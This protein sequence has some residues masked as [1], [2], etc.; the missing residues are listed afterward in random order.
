MCIHI[1][2]ATLII[3]VVPAMC[4]HSQP[5]H[6]AALILLKEPWA[7]YRELPEYQLHTDPL[8]KN[9][10]ANIDTEE[11]ETSCH[12]YGVMSMDPCH[13]YGDIEHSMICV[14]CSEPSNCNGKDA[15]HF[16][17]ITNDA[18][19]TCRGR[20]KKVWEK[21]TCTECDRG[22]GNNFIFI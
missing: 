16:R 4:T 5:E 14:E 12:Y 7:A 20:W 10:M 18:H 9:L 17:L 6:N 3:A 8:R 22:A 11:K 19:P 21:N 15:H 1:V 2:L 13:G